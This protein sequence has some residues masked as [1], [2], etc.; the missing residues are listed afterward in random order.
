L[1][2]RQ[3]GRKR[4]IVDPRATERLGVTAFARRV[5][6]DTAA[7]RKGIRNGRLEQ[8]LGRDDKGRVV[9]ADV[10]L[11]VQEWRRNRD[12]AKD[13]R[14]ATRDLL[15]IADI[16]RAI[17]RERQR[18]L[19]LANDEREGLLIRADVAERQEAE[20][21]SLAKNRLLGLPS[22]IKRVA[23]ELDAVTLAA[24]DAVIREALDELAGAGLEDDE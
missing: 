12:H 16:R 9:I 14:P 18:K 17:E 11:G 4:A 5:G 24:I 22:R 13:P 8:S 23:P 19:K 15:V 3:G 6:V 10:A 1:H 7:V 21:I 2:N 20:R